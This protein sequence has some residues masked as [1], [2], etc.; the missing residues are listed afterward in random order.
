MSRP[1]IAVWNPKGPDAVPT[2]VYINES[3]FDAAKHQRFDPS[4]PTP[5]ET[6]VAPIGLSESVTVPAGEMS[7]EDIVAAPVAPAP[8]KRARK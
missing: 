5:V 8:K 2:W 4:A 7:A 3:D 6:P 1:I